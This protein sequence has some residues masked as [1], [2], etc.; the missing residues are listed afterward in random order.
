MKLRTLFVPLFLTFLLSLSKVQWSEVDSELANFTS[1]QQ[2]FGM[3]NDKYSVM[4]LF[5]A[6]LPFVQ[7]IGNPVMRA[8]LLPCLLIGMAA[9]SV[10]WTFDVGT[11]VFTLLVL[12]STL[13]YGL[14]A[15][16]L[17]GYDATLRWL[18]LFGSTVVLISAALAATGDPHAIMGGNHEGAWRGL[19]G[20]K[21]TFGPFV[22]VHAL[23]TLYGRKRLGL[24]WL[25]VATFVAVDGYVL[26]NSRS[27]T[28]L[29]AAATAML[30]GLMFLPIRS[31]E[32][33]AI[34]RSVGVVGVIASASIL[35]IAPETVL[36]TLGRDTTLSNR[37]IMWAAVYDLTFAH[38]LGT[39]YG[40]G[41]G[42]QASIE[43]QKAVGRRDA[44][45]VQSGY[46][47]LALELGW[48]TVAMFVF[49]LFWEIGFTLVNRSSLNDQS[50]F[51]ALAVNHLVESYSESFGGIYPSWLLM[52][53]VIAL[54]ILRSPPKP[55]A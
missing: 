4:V 33:R 5:A 39:G 20:H 3:L 12:L 21:N 31:R 22:G 11:T 51:T 32:L 50:L 41:G 35:V 14:V 9:I 49:W 13:G 42:S 19:F 36:N 29:I 6:L 17:L 45:G 52:T 18:W 15:I 26:V 28:A 10:L 37:T 53:L 1:Q 27:G 44:Q 46:L 34:W 54:L 40:T 55:Q 43:V 7:F 38:K 24:P 25:V 48:V 8:G 16:K 23:L 2:T 47:N 30:A